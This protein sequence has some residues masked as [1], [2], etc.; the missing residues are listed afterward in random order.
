LKIKDLSTAKSWQVIALEIP[1][2]KC[3]DRR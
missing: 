2:L 1:L 3:L